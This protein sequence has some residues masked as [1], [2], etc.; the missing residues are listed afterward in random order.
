MAGISG[1]IPFLREYFVLNDL[2]LGMAVSCI[3]VGC[4]IGAM[5]VGTF[6]DKYGRK[7]LM[8]LT[9]FLF[10]ISALGCSFSHALWFFILSRIIGGIAVGAASVLGPTYISEIAPAE[11]RGTLVSNNQ[12]AIVIGILLAYVIDYGLVN[13]HNGWRYMLAVP[14]V[15]GVINLI[16]LNISFPESPRWLA[17]TGRTVASYNVFAKIGGKDFADMELRSITT[18]LK[19]QVSSKEVQFNELFKGKLAY[20]MLLGTLL[21]IFQQITGINAVVNYAPS[22][23][24]KT[25]VGG[26]TALLQSIIVGFVNFIFTI[27]AVRLVDIWGRKALLLW[28]SAGMTASLVYLTLTFAFNSTNGLGVLISL[29]AY[30]AFFAESLAPVMWVVTSEMYP[31]RYRGIAMS[32][33]TG[34]SWVFT[35][36]VVQFFPWMLNNLGGMFSFG[37]FAGFSLLAFIFI[38]IYIPETKGKSLE[39][40]ESDLGLLK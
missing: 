13:V 33:S 25:G 9:A 20:I 36:L 32:F 1:A 18:S 2:V 14:F 28:G 35:M 34:V 37:I 22:I 4:F 27:V 12:L 8:M 7:K 23:F 15:F 29:L 3:M 38:K 24:Q 40:I 16:L 39:Q 6:S 19:N 26:D 11:R 30:I 5:F 21:A 17:K 10:M 31:T